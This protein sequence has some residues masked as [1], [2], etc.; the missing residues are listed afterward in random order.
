MMK[1][2]S[3]GRLESRVVIKAYDPQVRRPQDAMEV[4]LK[5]CE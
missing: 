2:D 4:R 1:G 5:P 3:D